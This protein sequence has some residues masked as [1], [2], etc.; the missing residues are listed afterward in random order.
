MEQYKDQR[1][2]KTNTHGSP[3]NIFLVC[4]INFEEKFHPIFVRQ[5]VY[6]LVILDSVTCRITIF[7]EATL[8]QCISF[9]YLSNFCERLL[10]I[11][12]ANKQM[13]VRDDTG[14]NSKVLIQ[15]NFGHSTNALRLEL[16]QLCRKL[17]IP[18]RMAFSPYKI[19]AYFQSSL[20]ILVFYD[21][22]WYRM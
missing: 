16:R 2:L 22:T 1:P 6:C 7:A 5:S 3:Q 4:S 15:Q 9:D 11:C 20:D 18:E 17:S 19:G 21:L 8:G 13:T 14:T 12:K 10:G